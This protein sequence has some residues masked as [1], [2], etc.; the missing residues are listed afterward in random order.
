MSQ[1]PQANQKGA[2]SHKHSGAWRGAGRRLLHH[3]EPPAGSRPGTLVVSEDAHVTQVRA[4]LYEE[5]GLEELE[6][7]SIEDVRKILA[8]GRKCWVDV[9]GLGNLQIITDIAEAFQVH[10]LA[11]EDAVNVPQRP[12]TQIFETH[13]Q[14]VARGVRPGSTPAHI[15]FE[16]ISLFVGEHSLLTIQEC[17]DDTFEAIRV[18]LRQAKGPIRRSAVGYLAYAILDTIVDGYF[19][20]FE[21]FGDHLEELES[22]VLLEASPSVLQE[23]N[24]AKKDLLMLRRALWPQRE[25]VN[26]LTREH[27]PYFDAQTQV[28]LHDCYDHC[29]QLLDVVET[30]REMASSLM[31][32]YLSAVGNR[33]NDVMKV[34]TIMASIFIPLTFL[35]G[36]YGMNFEYMPELGVRWAYPTL[37]AVMTVVGVGMLLFFRQL[38]W[39]GG[40]ARRERRSRSRQADREHDGGATD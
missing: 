10:P 1:R 29:V 5:G 14:V 36:I 38:G 3:R 35:A 33:T 18:R 6:L 28:Y 8:D 13:Q 23:V 11:L 12:D 40:A 15:E 21:A 39:L 32:T 24:G 27:T 19:P 9:R 25:M 22:K 2:K 7:D 17:V 31:S 34:L 4:V 37:L 30:Y 26:S 16:Q 20:M